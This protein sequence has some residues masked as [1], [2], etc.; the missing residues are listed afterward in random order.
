MVFNGILMLSSIIKESKGSLGLVIII[1][2][3]S[4]SP[5]KHKH[6]IYNYEHKKYSIVKHSH[7]SIKRSHSILIYVFFLMFSRW[8]NNYLQYNACLNKNIHSHHRP[9]SMVWIRTS[10]DLHTRGDIMCGTVAIVDCSTDTF[11]RSLGYFWWRLPHGGYL[12][13]ASTTGLVKMTHKTIPLET[14]TRLT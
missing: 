13:G 6:L 4:P 5:T 11:S 12:N 14:A 7:P 10:R 1:F 3:I 9:L 2:P 8:N